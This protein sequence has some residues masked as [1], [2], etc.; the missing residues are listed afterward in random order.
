MFIG[1]GLGW[2]AGALFG[3]FWIPLLLSG[4][5]SMAGVVAGWKIT[6]MMD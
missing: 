4:L 5:M 1:S 3:E 2:Y 6:Q